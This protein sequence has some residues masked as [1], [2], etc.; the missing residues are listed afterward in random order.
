MISLAINAQWLASKTLRQMKTRGNL[1]D[2]LLCCP[3]GQCALSSDCKGYLLA[4]GASSP[5]TVRNG[6]APL[7]VSARA[8]VLCLPTRC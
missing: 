3:A 4:G 5:E 8:G 1:L 2:V 7:R 6:P